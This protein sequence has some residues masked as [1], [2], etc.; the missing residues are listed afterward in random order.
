MS[1]EQLELG[2]QRRVGEQLVQHVERA[3]ARVL[4]DEPRL[5]EEEVA[6]RRADGLGARP[7]VRPG[8][9]PRVRPLHADAE[10]R[11]RRDGGPDAGLGGRG[12]RG[13][14]ARGAER[15]GPVHAR[16]PGGPGAGR[17][18]DPRKVLPTNRDQSVARRMRTSD[19]RSGCSAPGRLLRRRST[20]FRTS[21]MMTTSCSNRIRVLAY[22][23][24]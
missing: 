14:R 2:A 5:L 11:P 17:P 4:R 3:L 24:S 8:D 6:G 1:A 22:T 20:Q 23:F 12:R 21:P 19:E 15:G 18:A 16:G 13:R 10:D 9:L 7:E